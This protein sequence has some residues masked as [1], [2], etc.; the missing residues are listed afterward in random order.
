MVDKIFFIKG[1]PKE[2]FDVGFRPALRNGGSQEGIRVHATN[3]TKDKQVRV[4][5]SGNFD[6]IEVF[7]NGIKDK[8]LPVLEGNPM[9]YTVT[10]LDDYDGVDINWDSYNLDFMSEQLS[11][12]I[13]YYDKFFNNINTKLDTIHDD[14]KKNHKKSPHPTK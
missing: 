5:T 13:V 8:T 6:S 1:K 11:K 3:M 10:H 7:Y 2:I 9:K 4:I 12:S 14:T